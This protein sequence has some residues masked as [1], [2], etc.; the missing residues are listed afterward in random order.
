MLLKK[1]FEAKKI[2]DPIPQRPTTPT[3]KPN[4]SYPITPIRLNQT[5]NPAYKNND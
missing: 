1:F 2:F 5:P 4:L 3:T